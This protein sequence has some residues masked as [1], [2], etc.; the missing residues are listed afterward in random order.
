M[1]EHDLDAVL[2][3]QSACYGSEFREPKNAFAAKLRGAPESCW[4]CDVP[5][6]LLAYLVCLPVKGAQLPA[7]H[8]P[9]WHTSAN[10]EWLYLHDLAIHPSARGQGVATRMLKGAHE[11]ALRQ[12]LAWVGLIAVQGSVPFWRQH[13]FECEEHGAPRVSADKLATFG[14]GAT[15]ML[16]RL[17]PA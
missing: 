16:R 1:R 17:E 8:A 10:P 12:N 7:L 9:L 4:V 15:F 5:E 14:Q 11:F 13:G 2:N 6:G 3:L